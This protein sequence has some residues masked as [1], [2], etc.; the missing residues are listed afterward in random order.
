MREAMAETRWPSA[1]ETSSATGSDHSLIVFETHGAISRARIFSGLTA[2]KLECTFF[3]DLKPSPETA[4]NLVELSDFVLPSDPR[5]AH[6][7]TH[8]GATAEVGADN[9]LGSYATPLSM[10]KMSRWHPSAGPQI[11]TKDRFPCRAP[12]FST[13]R[14]MSAAKSKAAGVDRVIRLASNESALGPSPRAMA[15]FADWAKEMH[16]YPD[17]GSTMLR[18]GLAKH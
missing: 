1:E 4:L 12:A 8:I 16:R 15:A 6:F 14:P 17:G 11:M 13:S 5:L 10:T 9:S 2:C 7:K 3:A 18:D